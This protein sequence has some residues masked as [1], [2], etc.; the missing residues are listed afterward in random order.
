MKLLP[1]M[2]AAVVC[3]VASGA[4]AATV[5]GADQIQITS[6]VN[7]YLQVAEV[8]ALDFG[9]VDVAFTGNGGSVSAPDQYDSTTQPSN[10]IDGA[11]PLARSYS[12]NPGIYHSEFSSGGLLDVFF[13]PA[14]LSSLSIYGRTDC[15][16]ERDVYNVTI[17][18]AAGQSLY[19]GVLNANNELHV[20]SVS[21]DNPGVA[22][23]EPAAWALMILGFG[24]TGATLRRR[25]RAKVVAA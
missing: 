19:S 16:S 18:N 8:V 6:A 23:P 4:T 9:G 14:T 17:F 5:I 24:L 2:V 20:G 10:A 15:C 3:G 11:T 12:D 21:F 7:S 13:A 22:V 25:E 1:W